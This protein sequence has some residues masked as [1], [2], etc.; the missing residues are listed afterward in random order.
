MK[1][2]TLLILLFVAFIVGYVTCYLISQKGDPAEKILLLQAKQD[3]LFHAL[4]IMKRDSVID[5]QYTDQLE[6]T[7]FILQQDTGKYKIVHDKNISAN[8]LL[9]LTDKVR[10]LSKNLG[11]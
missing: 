11:D 4:D 5:A 2:S 9:P 6:Q 1:N 7:I 10:L 3:S 8:H